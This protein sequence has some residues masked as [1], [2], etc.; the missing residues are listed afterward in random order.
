MFLLLEVTMALLE[1][2]RAHLGLSGGLLGLI[3]ALLGPLGA[4]VCSSGRLRGGARGAPEAT[5]SVKSALIYVF[6]QLKA[7][8]SFGLA[9]FGASKTQPNRR[10]TRVSKLKP[11]ILRCF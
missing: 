7:L 10:K 8:K 3:L 5:E 4:H 6:S 11:R 2:P 9:A 1:C